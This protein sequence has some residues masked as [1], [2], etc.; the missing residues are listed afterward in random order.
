MIQHR[1]QFSEIIIFCFNIYFLAANHLKNGRT[2]HSDF[3]M[4][5]VNTMVTFQGSNMRQRRS[6]LSDSYCKCKFY[7]KLLYSQHWQNTCKK[8]DLHNFYM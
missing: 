8:E 2:V 4:R 6:Y 3:K 5:A 7:T 1:Q